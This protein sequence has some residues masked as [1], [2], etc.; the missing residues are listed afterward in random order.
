M[1]YRLLPEIYLIKGAKNAI[2]SNVLTGEMISLNPDMT[3][4]IEN[5]EK[6]HPFDQEPDDFV[7]LCEIGWMQKMEEPVFV[8]KIRFTNVF[9]KRR[10]WRFFPTTQNVILQISNRCNGSCTHTGCQ[11]AFCPSCI[12]YDSEKK[13]ITFE[14]W[15]VI[16]NI[17]GKLNPK[18]VILTGGNPILHPEFKKIYS[19]ANQMFENVFVTISEVDDLRKLPSGCNVNLLLFHQ[20]DVMKYRAMKVQNLNIVP[21]YNQ[22]TIKRLEGVP[23]NFGEVTFRKTSFYK[24]LSFAEQFVRRMYDSCLNGK[25]TILCDGSLVPCMGC[26]DAVIGNLLE[27][28]AVELMRRLYREY[29]E[30]DVDQQIGRKCLGCEYRYNCTSCIKM[31]DCQCG[32]NVEEGIWIS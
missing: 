7:K 12:P 4:L 2:L 5:A 31:K 23:V 3:V 15:K 19:Y 26:K 17:L 28:D 32:Y 11:K 22:D 13:E 6:N 27:Q 18:S 14:Q 25:I 9:N 8:E 1:Y 21:Y 24:K 16:M 10:A 29:W 30:K 20:K